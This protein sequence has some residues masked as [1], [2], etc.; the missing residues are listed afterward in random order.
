MVVLRTLRKSDE[1]QQSQLV[2]DV[3]SDGGESAKDGR[4]AVEGVLN[5]LTANDDYVLAAALKALSALMNSV[6]L[7]V[8]SFIFRVLLVVS[9]RCEPRRRRRRSLGRRRLRSCVFCSMPR[10]A[11]RPPRSST[12]QA[13]V[14]SCPSSCTKTCSVCEISP[15]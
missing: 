7:S 1:R 2:G 4:R 9:Y 11:L 15:S 10:A 12:A 3:S 5:L 6:C 13:Q 8:P 14:C